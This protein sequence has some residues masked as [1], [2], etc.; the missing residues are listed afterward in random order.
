MS[1]PGSVNPK[2]REIEIIRVLFDRHLADRAVALAESRWPGSGDVVRLAYEWNQLS[3]GERRDRISTIGPEEIARLRALTALHPELQQTV[4]ELDRRGVL[5][6][7]EQAALAGA[8][9]LAGDEQRG[10]SPSDDAMT[11]ENI[12]EAN[13]PVETSRPPE[14]AVA[15]AAPDPL[16]VSEP[17]AK[18][19]PPVDIPEELQVDMPDLD[20]GLPD[21][22]TFL[23]EETRRRAEAT[24][25]T[26]AAMERV[27]ERLDRAA[28][29]T[30]SRSFPTATL[31]DIA[32]VK[33]LD[34]LPALMTPSL[35]PSETLPPRTDDTNLVEAPQ[36]II[37]AFQDARVLSLATREE[38]PSDDELVAIA[39]ELGLGLKEFSLGPGRTREVF[40]GL[41]RVGSQI[42]V[43]AGPLPS[44]LA[45]KNLVIV[46]GRMYP[47]LIDRLNAGFADIPGTRATVKVHPDARVLLIPA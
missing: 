34:D 4:D 39:N 24:R 6:N 7:L 30:W 12:I 5:P 22:E 29:R 38:A 21:T 47:M 43:T 44:A 2:R 18:L 13:Q 16:E 17:E 1:D 40:G 3:P 41:G 8:A 19:T 42:K 46:H 20:I 37:D 33:P 11:D 9:S 15:E 32:P 23:E 45:A 36:R 26:E 14:E 10:T 31:P 25:E 28:E 27:R 35:R